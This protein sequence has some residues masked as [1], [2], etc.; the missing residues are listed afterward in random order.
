MFRNQR[1]R[2]T[3]V[4]VVALVLLAAM[5]AAAGGAR[6]FRTSDAGW[7]AQAITWLST[8]WSSGHKNSSTRYSSSIDPNGQPSTTTGLMGP[9]YSSSIDPNGQN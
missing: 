9:D 7:W 3:A 4:L 1:R 2:W 8:L 5:P 6:E